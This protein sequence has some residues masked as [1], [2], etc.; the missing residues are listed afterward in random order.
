MF[1]PSRPSTTQ[2]VVIITK[3]RLENN[4]SST[5]TTLATDY[6]FALTGMITILNGIKIKMLFFINLHHHNYFLQLWNH[7]FSAH[8]G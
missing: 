2:Q 3:T 1:F 5:T 6:L 7:K 8:S 4:S